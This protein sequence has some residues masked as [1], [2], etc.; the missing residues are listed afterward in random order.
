[1]NGKATGASTGSSRSARRSSEASS[2]RAARPASPLVTSSGG[3]EEVG[4]HIAELRSGGV[5]PGCQPTGL[6]Q[7]IRTVTRRHAA[8]PGDESHRSQRRPRPYLHEARRCRRRRARRFRQ[9]RASAVYARRDGEPG[10]SRS[11]REDCDRG[12]RQRNDRPGSATGSGERSSRPACMRLQPLPVLYAIDAG[13][14][15]RPACPAAARAHLSWVDRRLCRKVGDVRSRCPRP[16]DGD[17]SVRAANPGC[18]GRAQ[19]GRP[20]VTIRWSRSVGSGRVTV[21]GRVGGPARLRLQVRR[22]GAAHF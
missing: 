12:D 17:G 6:G 14:E 2:W 7:T 20:R 1:M 8:R 5:T 13:N 16:A 11:R 15:S 18:D 19:V 9:G 3:S 21:S 22:P 4:R 10:R